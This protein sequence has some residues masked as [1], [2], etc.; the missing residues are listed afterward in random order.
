MKKHS[1]TEQILLFLQTGAST[2]AALN[3]SSQANGIKLKAKHQAIWNLRR[4]GYI[5]DL[6]GGEIDLTAAGRA[7]AAAVLAGK[8]LSSYM[9]SGADGDNERRPAKRSAPESEPAREPAP[10]SIERASDPLIANARF[11]L[12]NLGHWLESD[13]EESTPG[14]D[15][16]LNGLRGAIE[17]LGGARA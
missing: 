9:R 5:R 4:A 14:I 3:A 16:A 7:A 13:L 1:V 2:H 12:A 11:W 8:S 15:G 6:S 17:L 10:R